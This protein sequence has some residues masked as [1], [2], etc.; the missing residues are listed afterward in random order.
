MRALEHIHL[1]GVFIVQK[2]LKIIGSVQFGQGLNVFGDKI[3]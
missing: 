2:A 1:F 3:R